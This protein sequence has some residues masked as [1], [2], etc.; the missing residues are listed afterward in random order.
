MTTDSHY[1][2]QV[3]LGWYLAWASSM[4]VNR[5]EIRF[6]GMEVSVVPLPTADMGGLAVEARW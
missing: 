5:T 4:A 2:S 3:F 6:S 1:P